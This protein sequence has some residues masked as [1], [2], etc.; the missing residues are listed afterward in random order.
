M[1]GA[2]PDQVTSDMFFSKLVL[3]SV[4]VHGVGGSAFTVHLD[5]VLD[6]EQSDELLVAKFDGAGALRCVAHES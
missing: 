5:Y 3:H 6:K 1:F 4:A 2:A